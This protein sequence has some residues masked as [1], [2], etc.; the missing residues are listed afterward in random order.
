MINNQLLI[1]QII[2]LL[3]EVKNDL[4]TDDIKNIREFAENN[5]FGLAYEILCT[6]LYEYSVQ[7]SCDYY[8]KIS[9]YGKSIQIQP[10]V[11]LPLK[12]LVVI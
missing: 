3:N 2:Q 1:S 9:L 10:S 8:N 12:E 6:Q 7:I 5:E 11:W 4:P